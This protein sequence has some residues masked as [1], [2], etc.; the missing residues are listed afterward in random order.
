MRF[1]QVWI[2]PTERGLEPGVEQKEFT[3]ED[4][5]GRW[6]RT[7]SPDG[8]DAVK[9]HGNASMLVSSLHAYALLGAMPSMRPPTRS[10]VTP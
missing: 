5:A 10:R 8:G 3:K 2:M 1:I 4:R 7:I 6:L 9:V